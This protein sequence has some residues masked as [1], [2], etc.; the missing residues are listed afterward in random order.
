[1]QN[2][3]NYFILVFFR[4]DDDGEISDDLLDEEDDLDKAQ[5]ILPLRDKKATVGTSTKFSCRAQSVP[6]NTPVEWFHE[7]RPV[8]FGYRVKATTE[9]D[10]ELFVL[11]LKD[12]KVSDSGK[13]KV[14]FKMKDDNLS[15]TAQL[16]VEGLFL[17][18][19]KVF[20][21]FFLDM[22]WISIVRA[23]LLFRA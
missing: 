16:D 11:T 6:E 14:V 23:T 3:L 17:S 22:N 2:K 10:G 8:K 9:E 12:L 5:I 7:D 15:S 18:S 21:L 1:L 4:T 19:M 13:Y 20:Y